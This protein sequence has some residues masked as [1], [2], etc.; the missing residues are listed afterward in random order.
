MCS[1]RSIENSSEGLRVGKEEGGVDR[2][3]LVQGRSTGRSLWSGSSW[4]GLSLCIFKMGL[5]LWG[6]ILGTVWKEQRN[7]MDQPGGG[8]VVSLEDMQIRGAGAPEGGCHGGFPMG[9]LHAGLCYCSPSFLP[10]L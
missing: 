5:E 4:W 1:R 7:G 10:S 2:E 6:R 3:L 8:G 9:W